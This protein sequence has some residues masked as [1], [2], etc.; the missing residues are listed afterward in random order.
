MTHLFCALYL[1]KKVETIRRLESIYRKQNT[2]S[3][4]PRR[5]ADICLFLSEN[6]KTHV[7]DPQASPLMEQLEVRSEHGDT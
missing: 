4:T 6:S 3:D 7:N 5:L 1:E 2:G